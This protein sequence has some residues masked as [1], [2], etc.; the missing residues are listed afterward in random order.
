MAKT[1]PAVLATTKPSKKA[2]SPLRR[3]VGSSSTTPLPT[4]PAT[5]QKIQSSP[6]SPTKGQS[7]S[8]GSSYLKAG[9]SDSPHPGETGR[10]RRPS[11][12][13]SSPAPNETTTDSAADNQTQPT[14][15]S[16]SQSA[17][18]S[19]LQSLLSA[20]ETTGTKGRTRRASTRRGVASWIWDVRRGE[21]KPRPTPGSVITRAFTAAGWSWG[22]SGWKRVSITKAPP[23]PPPPPPTPPRRIWQ[24][25][26]QLKVRL[27]P[28]LPT[29]QATGEPLSLL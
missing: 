23:P 8:K 26:P 28:T 12:P 22:E 16:S 6:A 27:S 9:R 5:P 4:P 21:W 29:T 10:R 3:P 24:R 7:A 14:A 11:T 19:R 17:H 15:N 20:S 2:P 13:R 18:H 25:R 1:S